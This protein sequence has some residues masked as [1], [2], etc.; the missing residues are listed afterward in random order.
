[1]NYELTCL[2]VSYTYPDSDPREVGPGLDYSM[3][4]IQ[5]ANENTYSTNYCSKNISQKHEP[6]TTTETSLLGY[7]DFNVMT[8]S[9]TSA[10]ACCLLPCNSNLR[11]RVLKQNQS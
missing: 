7:V 6:R 5:F 2:L 9:R 3:D 8:S 1:M 10:N 11:L 4:G